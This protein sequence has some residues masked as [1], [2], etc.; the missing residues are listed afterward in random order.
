[1]R[2]PID[3]KP[4]PGD[5]V[6]LRRSGFASV[7]RDPT[8]LATT[9]QRRPVGRVG[10]GSVGIVVTHQG[11]VAFVVFSS[12]FLMG[13]LEDGLLVRVKAR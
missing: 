7:W 4:V 10:S 8:A 11:H 2:R 6:V 9:P 3:A 12:P 5:L 1:M 13:W